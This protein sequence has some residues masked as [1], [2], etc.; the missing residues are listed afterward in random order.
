MMSYNPL[1]SSTPTASN[2]PLHTRYTLNGPN[3]DTPD[4]PSTTDQS[5]YTNDDE[6]PKLIER[7][8]D[9]EDDTTP[10]HRSQTCRRRPVERPSSPPHDI[11]IQATHQSHPPRRHHAHRA[12]IPRPTQTI[13]T[14]A[15]INSDNTS[16]PYDASEWENL[17]ENQ[18]DQL[19][20]NSYIGNTLSLPK[21]ANTTR[22][23][24]QN[25][26]GITLYNP[27][28]WITTCEHL[29]DMEVDVAMLME[30][31]LDTSQPSVMKRL[32][33]GGRQVFNTGAF[34]ITATSTPIPAASMFKPGGTLSLT[35]GDTKGRI[36]ENGQDPLGRWV[37]TK[38]RRNTGPPITVIATYQVVDVDPR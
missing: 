28:T 10:R 6:P 16:E 24:C 32:L 11:P 19:L 5:Q 8:S 14:S 18:S 3:T 13:H 31:K 1:T 4:K 7:D 15:D 29:R 38:F 17:I 27:G 9:S 36:L 22:I 35:M 33:D 37:Y 2:E 20:R 12:T 23:Y 21:E 25:V 26:N 34:T 30:H